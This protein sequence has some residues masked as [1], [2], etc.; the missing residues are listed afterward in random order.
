MATSIDQIRELAQAEADAAFAEGW[1]APT[2]LAVALSAGYSSASSIRMPK[3]AAI[4]KIFDALRERQNRL[5]VQT[6][7]A[8]HADG[9]EPTL[10]AIARVLGIKVWVLEKGQKTRWKDAIEKVREMR[11]RK[12]A[13]RIALSVVDADIPIPQPER[14]CRCGCTDR[15]VGKG[16]IFGYLPEC[17][18]EY[19]RWC[20]IDSGVRQ[21]TA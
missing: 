12:P 14:N 13:K 11:Q 15:T 20:Q 17:W 21:R 2:K 19:T 9:Q 16:L 7:E 5:I 3:S 18:A 4:Q 8:L 1:R 6:A 10:N